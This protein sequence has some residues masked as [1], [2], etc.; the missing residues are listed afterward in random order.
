MSISQSKSNK[1]NNRRS[2]KKYIRFERDLLSAIDEVRSDEE[3][4]SAWVK[5]ACW[6]ATSQA[7]P[8][9]QENLDEAMIPLTSD[10]HS[11]LIEEMSQR[12]LFN[13]QIA[14]ELNLREIKPPKGRRWTRVLVREWLK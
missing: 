8:S 3:S 5:R 2:I 9:D 12:G 14:D 4:F 6:L 10:L 13:Q 11:K 7:Q 1:N